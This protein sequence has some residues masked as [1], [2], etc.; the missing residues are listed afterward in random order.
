MSC[1]RWLRWQM[2]FAG[3]F[4]LSLLPADLFSQASHHPRLPPE[5]PWRGQS[6]ALIVSPDDPWITPAEKSGLTRTPRYDETVQWLRML[7]A[8]APE[9]KMVSLG[10]SLQ[11][12]DIWMVI[13]SREKAFTPAALRAS[14]KPV[15]LVQAGI[16]SGEID[17]KDAG[18]M[19]LR[20]L[21]VRRTKHELLD[22]VN[23]LFVPIFSVD[24]HERFSPY[25]RINQRGPLETGWR[26]T[27]RNLNLNRDYTKLDAAEMRC[28]VRALNEYD[29]DL[30]FDIHVTDGADYQYDITFGYNGPH[31]HSP[32][33]AAWLDQFLTP[34]VHRDLEAM[35]HIPGPL[36][37]GPADGKDFRT[38]MIEWTASP[39]F[40]NGYGDLRHLPTVLVENHSLKPYK[41]R[42]LGTYVLLES[43]LRVL[44][45]HG[46]ALQEAIATDRRRR[47]PE[48]PLA[49]RVPQTASPDS[50]TFLGVEA[51]E[52]F[53]AITNSR[54][55]QWT[56]KTYAAKIPL[57]KMSEAAQTVRRPTA[58]W[59]PPAW[60]EVIERLALHG[61][62][63][64]RLTAPREIAVEMYRLE[65]V[66]LASRP[67]EGHVSVSATAVAETTTRQFPAGTVRIAT[68][69][70]LGDLAVLLLEPASGDSFFRWGFFLECLS[71]AEYVEDYVMQPMA[72]AML[73]EDAQLKAAFQTK[74]Q[75]DSLFAQN[76]HERLQWFYQRTPFYDQEANL[77][78]VAR[79]L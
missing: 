11:G 3:I 76:P 60:P 59:I 7:C 4:W 51:R 50:F 41:Q 12:R 56:G 71:P 55:L 13:A 74:V 42:V 19:L 61:I 23:L 39:R 8:A 53:S 34:A 57:K 65:N 58:Y 54:Y 44:A 45:R 32:A 33:G 43:T 66:K 2:P 5:L 15:F 27:A 22:H 17:G 48:V 38:G 24:A 18:M 9:L 37:G 79:E 68:D 6:E 67:F 49:W 46:S 63:M 70:P 69:Q 10:K 40:S 21:T 73:A 1:T 29:P 75:S 28:L 72:E 78:P 30:Y 16:H 35:G 62:Q 77:Y 64:E 52:V 36:V 26:T 14:R 47:M 25:N 31:A 20:D